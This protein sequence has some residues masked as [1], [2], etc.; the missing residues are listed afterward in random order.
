MVDCEIDLDY[1]AILDFHVLFLQ[2]AEQYI[3]LN[4]VCLIRLCPEYYFAINYVSI[5]ELLLRGKRE[6]Q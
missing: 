5:T 2:T 6:F 4:N 3:D 1:I